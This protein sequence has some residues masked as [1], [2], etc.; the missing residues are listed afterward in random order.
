MT[1]NPQNESRRGGPSKTGRTSSGRTPRRH[2]PIT[3]WDGYPSNGWEEDRWERGWT[4]PIPP[5]RQSPLAL[6]IVLLLALVF[7]WEALQPRPDPDV[8]FNLVI[9]DRIAYAY[10]GTDAESFADV[11]QQLDAN[12]QI[13]T[14]VLK[15]VPGTKHLGVNTRIAQMIR[16][17]GINTHLE[18]TSF[19]ASGGVDLFLAGQERTMECGARIGVHSWQSHDGESPRTLG[20]DPIEDRMERFHATLDIDP[21]FYAFARD[22]APHSSLYFLSRNDLERFN[23]LTHGACDGM[24][25]LGFLRRN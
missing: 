25:W 1:W 21:D 9:E 23:L 22:A 20:H 4:E 11:R 10:G 19:I 8:R 17:R 18:N 24:D 2:V 12:P 3:S 7:I 5:R 15:H 6:L 14:I 13:E 16:A